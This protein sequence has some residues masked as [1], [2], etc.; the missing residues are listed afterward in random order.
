MEHRCYR[1][2]CYHSLE[3]YDSGWV[4]KKK[5]GESW[6]LLHA[7]VGSCTASRN[8]RRRACGGEWWPRSGYLEIV[9]AGLKTGRRGRKQ[10]SQRKDRGAIIFWPFISQSKLKSCTERGEGATSSMGASN[11][12]TRRGGHVPYHAV[13]PINRLWKAVRGSAHFEPMCT[14]SGD[15]PNSRP[16]NFVPSAWGMATD[17]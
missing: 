9:G 6:N 8:Q 12:R 5:A 1:P 15:G 16:C 14:A 13:R 11:P 2:R 17:W 3:S 7:V 10:S 4:A